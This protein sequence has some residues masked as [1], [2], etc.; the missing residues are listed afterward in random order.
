MR[1]LFEWP[2]L[3]LGRSP[4]K[5]SAIFNLI[6]HAAFDLGTYYCVGGISS[7]IDILRERAGELGVK[8][9]H[10]ELVSAEAK[11]GS[12]VRLK[13]KD[14]E[15][16]CGDKI[17]C[18]GM[19]YNYF[20]QKILQSHRQYGSFYWNN[21]SCSPSCII[22]TIGVCCTE[23]KKLSHHN[24]IF[25]K[26]F[27]NHLE[28]LDGRESPTKPSIYVNIPTKTDRTLL[29]E[30]VRQYILHPTDTLEKVHGIFILVP[31]ANDQKDS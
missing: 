21:I 26:F 9:I 5:L 24:M 29:S 4:K 6:N 25:N 1:I 11:D 17:V 30:K 19:D 14:K 28:S 2:T 13:F 3:F 8:I 16:G 22:F 18:V 15:V 31:L 10:S 12:L 7:L 20:E 27:D 23:F